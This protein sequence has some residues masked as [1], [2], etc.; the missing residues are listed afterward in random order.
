[1]RKILLFLVIFS[2]SLF[3][4]NFAYSIY[5]QVKDHGQKIDAAGLYNNDGA[6]DETLARRHLGYDINMEKATLKCSMI[7]INLAYVAC[8]NFK[9]NTPL[10][11][12]YSL[13][14]DDANKQMK[15]YEEFIADERIPARNRINPNDFSHSGYDRGHLCPNASADWNP[16]AQMQTFLLSNIAPQ[17]RTLN[18]EAWGQIEAKEREWT[19]FF[20][21]VQVIT[22]VWFDFSKPTYQTIGGNIRPIAVPDFWYKIVYNPSTNQAIAFWVPNEAVGKYQWSRYAT[23][24]GDIEEKTG[25]SFFANLSGFKQGQLKR[26]IGDDFRKRMAQPTHN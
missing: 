1:M 14:A 26:S 6:S 7:T 25:I 2:V 17:D 19:N 22:G 15:R 10:W 8:Y 13:N 20:G 12:S 24:V 23:T 4:K 21:D 18:R 16:K 3:A 5:D 9:T 11:S